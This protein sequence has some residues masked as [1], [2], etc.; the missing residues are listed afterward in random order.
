[1]SSH[2]FSQTH[3]H[4]EINECSNG[5]SPFQS[6]IYLTTAGASSRVRFR[7][8]NN[9]EMSLVTSKGKLSPQ[10]PSRL[11]IQRRRDFTINM[12]FTKPPAHSKSPPSEER[13]HHL[14]SSAGNVICVR[15]S[16]SEVF[17]LNCPRKI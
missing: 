10:G 12:E 8:D 7:H 1:M 16:E 6:S 11:K 17:K 4:E 3:L 2:I 15:V 13:T 14:P 5:F 9:M